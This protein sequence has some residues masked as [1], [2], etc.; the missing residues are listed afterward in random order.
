MK[1]KTQTGL[2]VLFISV[3]IPHAEISA[4]ITLATIKPEDENE[5]DLYVQGFIQA[6]MMLNFQETGVKDG[7]VS[8]SIE[9]PQHNV[10][11]GNFSI[12]QS[13]IGLGIQQKKAK[14]GKPL[15]AYIEIDF[16]GPNGTTAPRFR[17][18]YLQW[19]QW[20]LGQTWSNFSDLDI[21]PNIFDFVP[22]NAMVFTRRMQVRYTT[23]VSKKG[24]LSLSMEDPD[25]PSIT[26]PADSLQWKKKAIIPNFT[27]LYR[28]GDEKNYIKLGAILSPISY[29]MKFSPQENYQTQTILGWGA[30]ISGKMYLNK[31]NI[32]SLQTSFG[33]GFS[34][35]NSNLNEEKYD[36]IP[37]PVNKNLLKTLEMFNIVG[38]YEH[39]WTSKWSSVTFI[40]HSRIG[41]ESFIPGNMTKSFQNI[42]MNIVFQ[43]YK[44]V[45]MG[46]EAN[47][48]RRQN[49]GN[50]SA[51]AWRIQASTSVKF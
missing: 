4:Q 38:I 12:K 3:L 42:G 2:I 33:K 40:S 51:H 23:P 14:N 17:Q 10:I 11:T 50:Q 29:E 1:K 24:I 36:A 44:K 35:N 8:H 46:I 39:W 43:P 7:F 30:V 47:Y 9:I 13:Q 22:P 6:D 45:R 15:S 27:A 16:Y 19:N 20:L 28:Y 34:T 25:T 5:W 37:D 48:G 31:S 18:G 49:F 32:I 21:F 26:L 41:E